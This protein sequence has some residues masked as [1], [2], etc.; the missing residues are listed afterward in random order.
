MIMWTD[1]LVFYA[2]WWINRVREGYV[3]VRK[4]YYPKQVTKYRLNHGVIDCIDF[5]TKNPK[6]M[7]PYLEELKKYNTL[8]YVTITPYDKKIELNVP[9]IEKVIPSFKKLV[10]KLPNSFVGW[11]Y[12]SIFLTHEYTIERHLQEFE[13][14]TKSLSGYTNTCVISFLDLYEKVKR[15]A[16]DLICPSRK[17]QIKIAT[18]MKVIAEKYGISLYACCEG[19]FLEEYGINCTDCKSK[20]IIRSTVPD[21]LKIPN[22]KNTREG[23]QCFMGSDIGAYNTC[24]HFCK[25]CYANTNRE[26]VMNNYRK[27]DDDSPLLIGSL[28][29]GAIVSL[30]NGQSYRVK[31]EQLT[32]F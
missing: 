10:E 24:L 18:C 31:N 9:T 21:K 7:L 3:M 20:G 25:Y 16:S 29:E 17:E 8:W 30:K 4:P 26:N 5:C 28:E 6:P 27:H 32:L 1:I 12:D 2:K 23:C 11:R 13:K 22:I 15:N 19:A 14:I